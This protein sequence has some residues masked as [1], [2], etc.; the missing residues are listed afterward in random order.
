MV[1]S[2]APATQAG[3]PARDVP[4][5]RPMLQ[6]RRNLPR[7]PVRDMP[8]PIYGAFPVFW[9]FP[10][11]PLRHNA[12]LQRFLVKTGHSCFEPWLG[13]RNRGGDSIDFRKPFRK[14]FPKPFPK[15]LDFNG[16]FGIL[17]FEIERWSEKVKYRK[18][19]KEFD[20]IKI[21]WKI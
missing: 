11:G 9:S 21:F 6:K 16:N 3:M 19:S 18:L 12:Q 17:N 8:R 14:S 5:C 7:K 15:V 10:G 1:S 4:A 20:G 13:W 2:D